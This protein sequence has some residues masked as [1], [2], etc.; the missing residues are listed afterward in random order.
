MA[1]AVTLTKEKVTKKANGICTI[2]V[3]CVVNDGTN[4]IFTE[5]FNTDYNENV[6]PNLDGLKADAFNKFK[7]K[8]NTYLFEQ[9]VFNSE[10]LDS[11]ITDMQTMVTDYVNS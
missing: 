10:N 1:Y 3:K 7:E 11:A 2:A 4:D 9:G 8:W 6:L 5:T